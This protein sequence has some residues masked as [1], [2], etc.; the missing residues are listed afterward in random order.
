MTAGPMASDPPETLR[1]TAGPLSAEIVRRIGGGVARFDIS[2]GGGVTDI[3]R[4]WPEGGS[5]D[6]ETFGMLCRRPGRTASRAAASPSPA[7]F[8]PCRRRSPAGRCPS[9]AT[10]GRC[11]GPWWSTPPGRCA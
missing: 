6:P 8:I 3:F 4:P 11:P 2:R 7:R 9:T 1:L 5:R 10:H